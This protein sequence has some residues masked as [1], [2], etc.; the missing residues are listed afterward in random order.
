MV[1][2]PAHWRLRGTAALQ[3]STGHRCRKPTAI[4][5]RFAG[6][7]PLRRRREMVLIPAHRRLR[8]TAALQAKASDQFKLA[9]RR[10][11]A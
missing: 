6:G 8:G 3:A 5:G 7:R 2:I 9:Q 10:S 1:L 4:A 11:A